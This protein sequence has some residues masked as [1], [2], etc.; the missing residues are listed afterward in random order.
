MNLL[1]RRRAL[2][3]LKRNLLPDIY[4]KVEYLES[5]GTQFIDTS[6][7]PFANLSVETEMKYIKGDSLYA[8]SGA[9]ESGKT[10]QLGLAYVEDN[11]VRVSMNGGF[12][13]AV[14]KTDL[15]INSFCVIKL[16]N[17]AQYVN[18][19]LIGN[20][21][22]GNLTNLN[23]LLFARTTTESDAIT[24]N[25]WNGQIKSFKAW[26]NDVLIRNLVPCY[27]KADKVAGMYDMVNGVFYTN[28][29]AGQFIIGPKAF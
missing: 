29:G 27:R 1:N 13:E 18:G 11:T 6:L 22:Y 26:D 16:S 3:N 7:I 8:F 12:P 23:F 19:E 17:G 10:F 9:Y 15:D 28:G 4:Q 14:G 5:T 24:I 2:I 20:Q 21:V 25:K